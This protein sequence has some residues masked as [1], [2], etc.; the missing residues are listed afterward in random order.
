MNVHTDTIPEIASQQNMIKIYLTKYTR[1]EGHTVGQHG[2]L[3]NIQLR[4]DHE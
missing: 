3:H 4:E 1:N 2:P